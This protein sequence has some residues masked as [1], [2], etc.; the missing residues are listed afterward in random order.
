MN[1]IF[2]KGL[3][4]W[5]K[6]K[7]VITYRKLIRTSIKTFRPVL[8]ITNK[9]IMRYVSMVTIFTMVFGLGL[10]SSETV[11]ADVLSGFPDSFGSSNTDDIPD[12][13]DGGGAGTDDD[14]DTRV[15]SGSP[16]TESSTPQHTRLGDGGFITRTVDT[17]GYENIVLKYYWR[18]DNDADG[19]SDNLKVQWKKTSDPTFLTENTHQMDG[20]EEWSSQ[21]SISL[22]SEAD[23]TSIDIRF[24]GDSNDDDDEEGRVDDVSVE[25]DLIADGSISG[26]KFNDLD[27]DGVWDQDGDNP[28]PCIWLDRN[29]R[30]RRRGYD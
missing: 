7:T 5:S 23:N 27:G 30:Q 21:E 15:Q 8:K 13:I 17:T 18:G 20:N 14:S 16:R 2:K 12:W 22:P 9:R 4:S 19:S 1:T 28:E 29:L 6:I 3:R 25:G 26:Y 24:W 10:W 11:S